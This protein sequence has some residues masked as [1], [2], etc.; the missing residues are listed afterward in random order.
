MRKSHLVSIFLAC[1]F[2]LTLNAADPGKVPGTPREEI[3]FDESTS[4]AFDRSGK[5]VTST[6]KADGSVHTALNGSFQNVMVAR[7][8]PDGVIETYCTTNEEDAKNW[9]ARTDGRPENL[10]GNAQVQAQVQVRDK[11]P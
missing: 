3:R 11:T 1:L 2:P 10:A 4:R 5:F 6:A 8:G 9:M 7:L